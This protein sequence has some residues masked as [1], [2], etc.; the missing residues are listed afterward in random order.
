M[1]ELGP[2]FAARAARHDDE[3]LFVAKNYVALKQRGVLPAGIPAELGGGGAGHRELGEMLR[4]LA[5]Y[6][7][8]TA[9]ALSMHTHQIATI[10]WRWGRDLRSVEAFLRSVAAENLVLVSSGGS[11]WIAGSG[12]AALR[13]A[14]TLP[15]G[16]SSPAVSRPAPC[17][18]PA[19]CGMI[20]KPARRC[21]ISRC[22]SRPRASPCATH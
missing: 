4:V 6:C 15:R 9:L 21:C 8:S 20:R 2:E 11:D 13:V 12:R 10:V 3:D 16:R 22:R 19:R 7:D 18:A 17:S 1:E 14:G 5:H